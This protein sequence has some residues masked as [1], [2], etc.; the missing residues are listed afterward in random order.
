MSHTDA[1]EQASRF[2]LGTQAIIVG[3]AIKAA[4]EQIHDD[5]IP[6]IAGNEAFSPERA[7]VY[8]VFGVLLA[9]FYGGAFR[10]AAIEPSVRSTV[11]VVKNLLGA[12]ALFSLFYL[13]GSSVNNTDEFIVF[14]FWLHLIDGVWFAATL[15]HSLKHRLR[16]KAKVACFFFILSAVTV[17][18]L[19]LHFSS[20]TSMLLL[21]A[22]S[23]FD[24]FAFKP[25]YIDGD[26]KF[27]WE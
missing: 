18:F 26:P 20:L 6:G 8:A 2:W 23:I 13:M 24:L 15:C 19:N 25:L 9:R 5:V 21:M 11:T 22:I 4:L 3:L 1:S 16:Q 17:I 27:I 14:V 7:L 12:T 10:F